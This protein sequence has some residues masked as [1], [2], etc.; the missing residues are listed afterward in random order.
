M[1]GATTQ[2]ST[3]SRS[4]ALQNLAPLSA[5]PPPAPSPQCRPAPR[6]MGGNAAGG[7]GALAWLGVLGPEGVSPSSDAALCPPSA[8][9]PVSDTG[10]AWAPVSRGRRAAAPQPV[11]VRSPRLPENHSADRGD[12]NMTPETHGNYF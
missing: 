10:P 11:G 1:P 4:G 5:G 12:G 8:P 9:L 2:T 6:A 3:R 7:T